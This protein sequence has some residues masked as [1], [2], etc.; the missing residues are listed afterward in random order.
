[1]EV[2]QVEIYL[3]LQKRRLFLPVPSR[4]NPEVVDI[5]TLQE[6]NILLT[7]LNVNHVKMVK[8]GYVKNVEH[9]KW[10]WKLL[11]LIV[12]KEVENNDRTC[13]VCSECPEGTYKVYG[14]DKPR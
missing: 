11:I 5:P 14:C 12:V 1:M 4:S 7:I 8:I 9:V 2:F 3:H 6:V 13:C 10:V